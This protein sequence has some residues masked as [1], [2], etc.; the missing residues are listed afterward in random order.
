MWTEVATG[1]EARSVRRWL[2]RAALPRAL[3]WLVVLAIIVS[4][5]A[6][7]DNV[8]P[9]TPADCDRPGMEFPSKEDIPPGYHYWE[10]AWGSFV[11]CND[12]P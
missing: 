7:Y 2:R 8:R 6:V 5:F 12:P 4:A 3:P 10:T 1:T 9:W 11:M